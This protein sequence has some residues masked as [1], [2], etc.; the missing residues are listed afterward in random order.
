MGRYRET[1]NNFSLGKVDSQITSSE[2]EDIYKRGLLELDNALVLPASGIQKRLG[3]RPTGLSH[4]LFHINSKTRMHSAFNPVTNRKIILL[5]NEGTH[6]T[7]NPIIAVA[8]E[9]RL[10]IPSLKNKNTM[11]DAEL[12]ENKIKETLDPNTSLVTVELKRENKDD[13]TKF[14]A[15]SEITTPE[16]IRISQRGGLVFVTGHG[17]IPIIIDIIRYVIYDVF[18]LPKEISTIADNDNITDNL[19]HRIP[20][21]PSN[22]NRQKTATFSVDTDFD[23]ETFSMR[24]SHVNFTGKV[25]KPR[26][27]FPFRTF[28][29]PVD[30]LRRLDTFLTALLPKKYN[31]SI[32]THIMTNVDRRGDQHYINTMKIVESLISLVLDSQGENFIIESENIKGETF[33]YFLRKFSVLKIPTYRF[34]LPAWG[35]QFPTVVASFQNRI[36][37]AGS[38]GVSLNY[39]TDQDGTIWATRLGSLSEFAVIPFNKERS[40]SKALEDQ[41]PFDRIF[42]NPADVAE[43]NTDPIEEAITASMLD[44]LA[45]RRRELAKHQ[46]FKAYLERGDTSGIGRP[47]IHPYLDGLTLQN[48]DVRDDLSRDDAYVLNFNGEKIRWIIPLNELQVGTDKAEYSIESNGN[49]NPIDP[50][51]ESKLSSYGSAPVEPTVLEGKVIFVQRGGKIIRQLRYSDE[52][53]KLIGEQLNILQ[54]SYFTSQVKKIVKQEN[55]YEVLWVLKKDGTLLSLSRHETLGVS[56]WS[57]HTFSGKVLDIAESDDRLYLLI[58]RQNIEGKFHT[59]LEVLDRNKIPKE[60]TIDDISAFTDSVRLILKKVNTLTH[61]FDFINGSNFDNSAAIGVR[62]KY[63]VLNSQMSYGH[64]NWDNPDGRS[65][66]F[67]FGFSYDGPILNS[68]VFQVTKDNSNHIQISYARDKKAFIIRI[69]LFIKVV[70]FNLSPDSFYDGSVYIDPAS[71]RAQIEINGVELLS[72]NEELGLNL[73]GLNF[74]NCSVGFGNK[75]SID[76]SRGRL[77]A[78]YFYSYSGQPLLSQGPFIYEKE[79]GDFHIYGLCSLSKYNEAV[80]SINGGFAGFSDLGLS[81]THRL[82]EDPTGKTVSVGFSYESL[83]ETLELGQRDNSGNLEEEEATRINRIDELIIELENSG[84]FTV[85]EFERD[86]T[87][88]RVRKKDQNQNDVTEPFSGNL[89]IEFD[90]DYTTSGPKVQIKSKKPYPLTIRSITF[91]GRSGQR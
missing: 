47:I 76:A 2:V 1:Q 71:G 32:D 48:P 20:Y 41:F 86:D 58:E 70:P 13:I 23:G 24:S 43:Y 78:S 79:P 37:Y 63:V 57:K 85:S 30:R 89:R 38:K 40:R 16:D 26:A 31:Q 59:Q 28:Q 27:G 64:Y 39:E 5:F 3:T 52:R 77:I 56:G 66:Q 14:H 15:F 61:Y 17:D 18:S 22:R 45:D 21:R 55:P 80:V 42:G 73:T 8:A 35:N 33:F 6:S 62:D 49:L 50:K 60:E 46:A 29:D 90:G 25:I 54:E 10:V 81:S 83:V 84:T 75:F 53:K 4:N 11:T 7:D 74:S 69:G 67:E 51:R 9:G 88:I 44:S 87:Q 68:T 34:Q 82:Q 19:I 36:L 65:H 72:I 12:D 91:R